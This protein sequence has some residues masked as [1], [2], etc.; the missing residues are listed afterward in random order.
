[1]QLYFKETWQKYNSDYIVFN[2]ELI[3]PVRVIESLEG[4]CVIPQSCHA[5]TSYFC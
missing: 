4:Q 3:Y 2:K 5:Q 1:M